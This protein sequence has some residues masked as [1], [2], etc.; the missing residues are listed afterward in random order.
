MRVKTSK[1]GLTLRVI[2]GTNSAL[3]AMDLSDARRTNCLGFTIERTDLETGDRRWLPNMLR[4]PSDA[5]SQSVTT[6]RAPLQKFR[7]GDYTIE[8]GKRY[9][10]RA[11]QRYGSAADVLRQG[12]NA[13]KPGAF[14]V[15]GGGA[16][17]EIRAENSRDEQTAVFFNRGA[18]ASEAY[19]RKFG[20]ND[21]AKI[22]EA[23]TW[24]S[25]GLEEA[26]LAFLAKAVDL[27]RRRESRELI[28]QE[29]TVLAMPVVR[30]K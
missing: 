19:V 27:V 4:F 25:R 18:A 28:E 12:I 30:P 20:Q 1:D 22:P 3:L 29:R 24:L 5:D 14:D 10:Y 26:I 7:W 2:T 13:E 21:P 8:P 17:A 9:R 23:L 11:V 6:A 15:I 16:V